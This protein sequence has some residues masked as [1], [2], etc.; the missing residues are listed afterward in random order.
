V[1]IRESAAHIAQVLETGGLADSRLE[2]EVLLRHVLGLGR[3][4]FFAMRNEN[5]TADQSETLSLLVEQRLT[6]KPLSYITGRRE[7]YGL[8]FE[9]GPDVL[10]PRQETEL[11]VDLALD[12]CSESTPGTE[13]ADVGTGC[14]SIAITIACNL[15]RAT[16]HAIDIS[17]EALSIADTNRRAHRVLNR[18]HLYQGDLL[19]PLPHP[20]DL[21]VSNPPYIRSCDIAGLAPEVRQEPRVS[22]DGGPDG[23]QV[24]R[25]LLQEAP[26]YLRPGG[27]ILVETAPEHEVPLTQAVQQAMPGAHLSFVSD[28]M[29]NPRVAVLRPAGSH[30][31]NSAAVANP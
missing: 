11:L 14:G 21:I 5:L 12:L 24:T 10:V 27:T 8:D 19:A 7:F 23:L 22:L 18:V 4:E 13:I 15:P 20:V 17:D 16:V 28:L 6:G 25:R 30:I 1:T 2:A 31:L 3:A 9:V 26:V 29:S